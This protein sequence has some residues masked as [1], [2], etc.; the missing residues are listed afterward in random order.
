MSSQFGGFGERLIGS[1]FAVARGA[2]K[3]IAQHGGVFLPADVAVVLGDDGKQD[4]EFVERRAAGFVAAAFEL[5]GIGERFAERGGELLHFGRKRVAADHL[6]PGRRFAGLRVGVGAALLPCRRSCGHGISPLG[7]PLADELLAGVDEELI[8]H[9][10]GPDGR[11][12]L[13]SWALLLGSPG[14]FG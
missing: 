6:R 1:R 3:R 5:G 10:L 14:D 4:G 7:W 2:G 11:L 12:G 8:E 9:V 13:L